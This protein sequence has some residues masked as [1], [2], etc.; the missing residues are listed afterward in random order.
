VEKEGEKG[1]RDKLTK[2]RKWKEEVEWEM[3]A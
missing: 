3:G 1:A 2:R